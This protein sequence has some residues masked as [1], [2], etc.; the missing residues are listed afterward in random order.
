MTSKDADRARD[1][2]AIANEDELEQLGVVESSC[3]IPGAADTAL[4]VD[5]SDA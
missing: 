2:V 3:R 5:Q 4:I 1:R